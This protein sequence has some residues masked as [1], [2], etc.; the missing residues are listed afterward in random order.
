MPRYTVTN[1]MSS[2][3]RA[4]RTRKN[5]KAID[6]A[7][8]IGKTGA[9]ISKLEKGVL[10]TIE[11][12]DFFNIISILTDK[13]DDIN[14]IIS[15][16]LRDS[17]LNYSK[18]ESSKEEWLL[19]LDYI[20]RIICVPKTYS[21]YISTY[22]AENNIKIELLVD[23]INSNQD[24]YNNDDIPNSSLDSAEKNYWYFNEGHSFIVMSV[25][26]NQIQKILNNKDTSANYSLLRC[27]L[28]AIYRLTNY[29]EKK[30]Y[31]KAHEKLLEMNIITLEEKID[32]MNTY[33]D[34]EKMH[35]VLDQ[36]DNKNL[37]EIDRQLY[38]NLHTI[39]QICNSFSELHDPKYTNEKISCLAN[40]MEI[41][42]ILVM[43]LFGV[44]LTPLKDIDIKLKRDFV[45]EFRSLVTKYENIQSKTNDELI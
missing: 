7:N 6:I 33:E 13:D 26:I 41:D 4:L 14:D 2:M 12:N 15:N 25:T 8:K 19:N 30:A 11:S 38:R 44:D 17:K 21:H 42:P 22:M 34:L 24:L 43:G 40:N 27:I 1:Q 18:E 28:F 37:P 35:T 29:E 9:Y 31:S 5:I 10:N 45:N 39:V 3:L 16:I 36:R 32:I 20:Y 23:F